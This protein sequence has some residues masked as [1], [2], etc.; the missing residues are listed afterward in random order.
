MET[1]KDEVLRKASAQDI[2]IVGIDANSLIDNTQDMQ[3]ESL[4]EKDRTER[5]R[6]AETEGRPLRNWMKKM[7]LT[8]IW[9]TQQPTEREYTREE[10]KTERRHEIAKRIDMI[11]VN[12]KFASMVTN[13]KIWP[14]SKQEWVSDHSITEITMAGP[15]AL[16]DFTRT[17]YQKQTFDMKGLE[18]KTEQMRHALREWTRRKHGSGKEGLAHLNKSL[19][20]FMTQSGI[21]RKK[22]YRPTTVVKKQSTEERKVREEERKLKYFIESKGEFKPEGLDKIMETV[23]AEAAERQTLGEAILKQEKLAVEMWGRTKSKSEEV[24]LARLIRISKAKEIRKE[25][26]KTR[27]LR[28]EVWK[29]KVGA[30]EMEARYSTHTYAREENQKTRI[31][32]QNAEE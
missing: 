15:L 27:K 11:L 8:D 1:L 20:E 26:Q 25:R 21:A 2:V 19:Y 4:T 13:S 6:R 23:V 18:G 10:Q 29:A 28:Q 30:G 17:T 14:N 7:N 12:E 16:R 31:R 9:R 32:Y 3:W 22:E 24:E 5:M